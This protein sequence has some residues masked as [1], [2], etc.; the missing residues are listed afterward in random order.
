MSA[1]KGKAALV[2]GASRGIG[3]EV[4]RALAA[5][6]AAVVLAARDVTRCEGLAA[7]ITQAGGSARAIGCDVARASDVEAAVALCRAAFGRLDILVNNAGVI[8]PIRALHDVSADDWGRLIDVNVKGVYHGFRA[9][10][11]LMRRAG[12]GTIV[13]IGSGA[14]H[15]PLEG[16]SAY[17][18]SK[19]AALM[20]GRAAHL[21]NRGRGV[22]VLS[23]SPGTVATDMQRTIRASGIN[24]VARLPWEAHVSPEEVGRAVVWMCGPAAD[25]WLGG[26]VSLR[27]EALREV[28]GL[29]P[30]QGT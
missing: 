6:G 5:E 9:A 22:R 27:D 14:A 10:L 1:L 13:T 28:I 20:L 11:P 12:A 17:C 25:E 16:W 4:A 18:T 7:E 29:G 26:E 19:A 21:E 2:T 3:A 23:L 30:R 8:E 15:Q 24:P